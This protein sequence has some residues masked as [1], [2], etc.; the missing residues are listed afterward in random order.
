MIDISTK[1]SG[2]RNPKSKLGW[3]LVGAA[4]MTLL[5]AACD[6]EGDDN[7]LETDM[8]PT[9]TVT[10]PTTSPTLAPTTE[11]TGPTGA[12]GSTGPTVGEGDLSGTIEDIADVGASGVVMVNDDMA[13]GAEVMIEMAGLPEGSY[14]V[15]LVEG[16][17]SGLGDEA[18]GETV[19]DLGDME[20]DATG[21][22]S[23]TYSVDADVEAVGSLGHAVVIMGDDDE[24]V[25]CAD[26]I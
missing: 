20:A 15:T 14:S 23:E 9:T 2:R 6:D 8:T 3:L 13:G 4:S 21:D 25:A 22:V 24:L 7:G 11:P 18:M 19:A 1:D 16:S 17:C 5:L 26:L 12:T 10:S